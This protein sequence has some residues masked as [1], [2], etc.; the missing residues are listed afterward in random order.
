MSA[1]IADRDPG[2]ETRAVATDMAVLESALREKDDMLASTYAELAEARRQIEL[3]RVALREL[4]E[5]VT[6][7]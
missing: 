7:A 6:Q 5:K 3:Y 4:Q 2:D 1:S